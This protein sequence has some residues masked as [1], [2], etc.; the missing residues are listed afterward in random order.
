MAEKIEDYTRQL[1][2]L[3]VLG[4]D[5]IKEDGVFKEGSF[6]P[7]LREFISFYNEIQPQ[8]VQ[9]T[10]SKMIK[11][12]EVPVIHTDSFQIPLKFVNYQFPALLIFIL[13]L[14]FPFVPIGYFILK[15]LYVKKTKANLRLLLKDISSLQFVIENNR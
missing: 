7:K 6:F 3:I 8:L 2:Y 12:N 10:K 11:K 9:L 5:I 13:I 4:N 15:F 1:K 14:V